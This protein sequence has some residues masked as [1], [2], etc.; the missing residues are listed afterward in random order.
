M[1]TSY[2]DRLRYS[3][4]MNYRIS[5]P[6]AEHIRGILKNANGDQLSVKRHAGK[7][8]CCDIWRVPCEDAGKTL[9][10]QAETFVL[11]YQTDQYGSYIFKTYTS[12][13]HMCADHSLPSSVRHYAL[14]PLYQEFQQAYAKKSKLK[15][16]A[17]QSADFLL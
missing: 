9:P 8:F 11:L 7:L 15:I 6:E 16:R 17:R 1:A 5:E 12:F 10:I 4:Y 13:T 2:E 14:D 3:R